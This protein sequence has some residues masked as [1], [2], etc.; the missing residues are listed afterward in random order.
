MEAEN[1][2]RDA[3]YSIPDVLHSKRTLISLIALAFLFLLNYA[4]TFYDIWRSWIARERLMLGVVVIAGAAFL[5]WDRRKEIARV[6]VKPS[7]WGA[8]FLVLSFVLLFLG[9]RAHL[10]F[11]GGMTGVFLR[12]VS[13]VAFLCGVALLLLGWKPMRFLWLPAALLLFMVPENYFT[14]GWL[15]VRLQHLVTAISAKTLSILGQTVVQKGQIIETARFSANVET[16]CIGLRSMV[17]AL[18]AALF[19][20]AYGLHRFWAKAALVLLAIPLTFAANLFRVVTTILLG[21]HVSRKAAEGF[22]HYF[23][24]MAIFAL[25]LA[26]L[27]LVLKVLEMIEARQEEGEASSNYDRLEKQRRKQA[28]GMASVRLSLVGVAAAGGVLLLGLGYQAWEIR[29]I[30]ASAARY[31]DALEPAVPNV[32]GDWIGQ[33]LP[34]EE[35]VEKIHGI[36]D[37]LYREYSAP[38]ATPIAAIVSYSKPAVRGPAPR[39]KRIIRPWQSTDQIIRQWSETIHTS[40]PEKPDCQLVLEH[41]LIA[42]SNQPMLVTTCKMTTQSSTESPKPTGYV[43]LGLYGLRRVLTGNSMHAA[44]VTFHLVSRETEPE[45]Q[46]TSAHRDFAAR[47]AEALTYRVLCTGHGSQ[48]RK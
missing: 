44:H 33:D 6:P 32:I 14:T 38:G 23:A 11:T 19:I 22:F 1:A 13:L 8:L 35:G 41:K 15:A 28:N 47:L 21:L 30:Q 9:T 24:G 5:V 3:A 18:P 34:I 2:A 20:G 31:P 10:I 26:G 43:K 16:E 4:W 17:T 48:K 29:G 39:K 42:S 25:C 7:G 12:G 36:T 45:N 37:V 40:T 27:L 46:I